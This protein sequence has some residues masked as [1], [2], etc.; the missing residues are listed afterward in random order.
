MMTTD[1]PIE[2]EPSTCDPRAC[3]LLGH[4]APQL[5][6]LPLRPGKARRLS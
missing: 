1:D 2:S 5:E 6:S 4:D 3:R